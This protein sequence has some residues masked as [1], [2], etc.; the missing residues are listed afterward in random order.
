MDSTIIALKELYNNTCES[1]IF[2]YYIHE[3]NIE[4]EI[5][6]ITYIFEDTARLTIY[7]QLFV[8]FILI[9]LVTVDKHYH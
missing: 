2:E 4:Q 5:G 3:Q 8:L 9:F 7:I 6:T 1:N